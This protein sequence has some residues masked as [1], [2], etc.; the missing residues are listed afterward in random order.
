MQNSVLLDVT[1]PSLVRTYL[2]FGCTYCLH[3]WDGHF[4][5]FTSQ[6]QQSSP[7]LS[8]I[9]SNLTASSHAS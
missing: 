8:F 9:T 1:P 7:S 5:D 2:H 4:R 6:Q 3:T